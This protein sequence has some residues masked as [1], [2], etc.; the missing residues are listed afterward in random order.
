MPESLQLPVRVLIKGAS[1]MH[2]ISERPQARDQFTFGRVIEESLLSA[3]Q[4]AD[5]WVAA[6][7][8]ESTSLS[9]RAWEPE[10]K[11]WSPDVIILSYGY[12][13]TIHLFLPRW[14]ERHANS[15]KARPGPVR[16]L[17]RRYV[18]RSLWKTLAKLQRALDRRVGTRGFG[19]R[20][21]RVDQ[22]LRAFIDRSREVGQPLIML[23]EFLRPG[24]RGRDWFPGMAARTDVLNDV[25][26]VIVKDYDSPDVVIVP[27]PDIL[28]RGLPPGVEPNPDGFHYSSA[29]HDLL[30]RALA[31]DIRSW[32]SAHP[33]LSGRAPQ[34]G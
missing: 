5:V 13:E 6:V 20:A 1:L 23:L 22:E 24:A 27:V 18:V 26:R 17:Y 29:G 9:F 7:A 34:S 12:Y 21:R 16:S 14:L 31:A 33:R 15:L 25:L 3:G 8:S 4:P 11:A 30:G 32:T 19:H 10:V 28:A 2:D